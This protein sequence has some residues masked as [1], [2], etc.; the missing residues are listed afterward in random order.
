MAYCN[1]NQFNAKKLLKIRNI[2]S[3]DQVERNFKSS[4]YLAW[5]NIDF[6]LRRKKREIGKQLLLH[7]L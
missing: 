2:T 7:Y 5:S 6:I 3:C 4:A 1:I